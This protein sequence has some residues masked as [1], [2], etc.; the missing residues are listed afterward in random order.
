ML[1]NGKHCSEK[2][3]EDGVDPY[4]LGK[5]RVGSKITETIE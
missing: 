3:V 1:V 2:Q 4:Y 5:V